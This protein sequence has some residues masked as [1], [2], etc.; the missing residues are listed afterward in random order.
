[1]AMTRRAR[2]IAGLGAGLAVIVIAGSAAWLMWPTLSDALEDKPVPIKSTVLQSAD[3]TGTPT[4][5]VAPA[6]PAIPDTA[7]PS[8]T[9][10]EA[11]VALPLEG[12]KISSQSWRRG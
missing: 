5:A 6:T 1:M 8:T 9:A 4:P 11:P 10:A 2:S 12:L 3:E 7:Q